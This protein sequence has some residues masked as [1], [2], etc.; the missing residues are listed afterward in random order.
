MK[1]LLPIILFLSSFITAARYIDNDEMELIPNKRS[2]YTDEDFC[3]QAR[4][5]SDDNRLA[6]LYYFD[7]GVQECDEG[8]IDEGDIDYESHDE[9]RNV[10]DWDDYYEEGKEVGKKNGS[11]GN[12]RDEAFGSWVIDNRDADMRY[13]TEYEVELCIN[14]DRVGCYNVYSRISA[15][16]RYYPISEDD[17]CDLEPDSRSEGDIV[18]YQGWPANA[19]QITVTEKETDP[20]PDPPDPIP[21]PPD[22]IPD[23]VDISF[24]VPDFDMA[25]N[26]PTGKTTAKIDLNTFNANIPPILNYLNYNDGDVTK[27][28]VSP[29]VHVSYDKAGVYNNSIQIFTT[30]G[31]N[32]TDNFEVTINKT[33]F[34]YKDFLY[35]TTLIDDAHFVLIAISV[36]GEAEVRMVEDMG[37]VIYSLTTEPEQTTNTVV[38]S[39]KDKCEMVYLMADQPITDI[40]NYL[41]NTVGVDVF[42]NR[43]L[44]YSEY[45]HQECQRYV[46]V[47]AGFAFEAI[48]GVFNT[49]KGI[50]YDLP[51]NYVSFLN[52]D[53]SF[54]EDNAWGDAM[55]EGALFAGTAGAGT[56]VKI[57]VGRTSVFTALK[58]VDNIILRAVIKANFPEGVVKNQKFDFKTLPPN[59][60]DI[61]DFQNSDLFDDALVV[62]IKGSWDGATSQKGWWVYH[63]KG[64]HED[65]LRKIRNGEDVDIKFIKEGDGGAGSEYSKGPDLDVFLSKGNQHIIGEAK[66]IDPTDIK[67]I[68]PDGTKVTHGQYASEQLEIIQY[69]VK[70]Q[71]KDIGIDPSD[72]MFYFKAFDSDNP[73]IIQ[74]KTSSSSTDAYPIYLMGAFEEDVV[75]MQ[76]KTPKILTTSPFLFNVKGQKINGNT[77]KSHMVP[78][79][80]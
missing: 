51:V 14:I 77:Y 63:D 43:E 49:I 76:E 75:Q 5:D 8:D 45:T 59:D 31:R 29:V 37:N 33:P 21:D 15:F 19:I 32:Y 40:N 65:V 23:P 39:L 78:V 9:N 13:E 6:T 22:P 18:T 41:N 30:D 20:I 50:V 2:F 54:V 3:V 55:M 42:E 64:S 44:N 17:V 25:V 57:W 69:A 73:N 4:F 11:T 12:L 67:K 34:D 56:S 27:L 10:I 60:P 53:Y 7:V 26:T 62:S 68:L 1:S 71:G 61:I 58:Q 35:R 72:E 74:K 66:D 46:G 80:K 48:E 28:I 52:N 70:K 79:I 16:D 47:G 38:Q 24:N 36:V